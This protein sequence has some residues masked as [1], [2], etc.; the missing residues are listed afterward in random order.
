MRSKEE[1]DKK[2]GGEED[3]ETSCSVDPGE[4]E[5]ELCNGRDDDCDGDF[6][7]E[8]EIGDACEEGVGQCA[9]TGRF[10]C[11]E[12]GEGRV[13]QLAGEP[14]QPQAEICDGLDQDCDGAADEGSVCADYAVE[15]CRVWLGFTSQ[16]DAQDYQSRP[17]W[18]DCP[19]EPSDND[20]RYRCESTRGEARFRTV[21]PSG[22]VGDGDYLA[23]AFTC[24]ADALPGVAA[25][26]QSHCAVYFGNADLDRDNDLEGA[27]SW[28]PCPDGVGID[29]GDPNLRCI[30]SQFDGFFHAVPLPGIVDHNDGFSV[31]FRCEDELDARRAL[32]LASAVEVFLGW[33]EGRWRLSGDD[34]EW[35]DCP[36]ATRDNEGSVRCVSSQGTQRFHRIDIPQVVGNGSLFSIMFRTRPDAP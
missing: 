29:A 12:G 6:D 7:E 36:A 3:A 31:A 33:A 24:D 32:G 19:E 4:P 21:E 9:R 23:V 30:H 2:A 26:I 1:E 28:G 14:I 10:I 17:D 11:A 22:W 25:W 18:G 34:A 20:G 5:R 16:S 13:C 8:Y 35:G 15:N 27:D